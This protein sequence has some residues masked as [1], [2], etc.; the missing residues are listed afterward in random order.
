MKEFSFTTWEAHCVGDW[1]KYTVK[2]DNEKEAFKKLVE[3]FYDKNKYHSEDIV[4]KSRTIS[5]PSHSEVGWINM[6]KWFARL[7]SGHGREKTYNFFGKE[8]IVDNYKSLEKYAKLHDIN[9][10]KYN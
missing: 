6:P 7:I 2:A 8:I 5:Y 9:I 10:N 3:F 1:Y 4:S